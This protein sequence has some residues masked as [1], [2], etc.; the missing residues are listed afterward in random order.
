MSEPLRTWAERRPR[1]A[2]LLAFLLYLP[3]L[4]SPFLYDDLVVIVDNLSIRDLGAPMSVLLYDRAR[5]LLNLSWAINYSMSGLEPWSYHLVNALIH[6]G[7]SALLA[8]LFEWMAAR[9]GAA[10]PRRVA[11]AGACFFAV[12]PMAVETVAYVASRSTALSALFAIAS[13]RLASSVLVGGP[14]WRLAAA[15]ALFVLALATKEEAAAVPL[16]LLLLDAFFV[17]RPTAR[18]MARR[19]S[20]HAPFIGLVLL[21]LVLRRASTG[22]WLPPPESDRLQYA[23]TQLAAFPVYLF[24]QLVPLDPALYRG[25]GP[26][27]SAEARL[28]LLIAC[29]AVVA[30][31]FAMRT[32]RPQ[33]S[34]AVAWLAA[35][36]SPS[37][38]IVPLGETMADHRAYVGGAGVAYCVGGLLARPG[39]ALPAV[40]L[41]AL[42]AARN[43][44]YQRV[45]ADPVSAWEDAVRRAPRPVAGLRLLA[46]AY[47]SRNDAGAAEAALL[48][49]VAIDATDYKSWTNLGVLY[50]RMGRPDDAEQALRRA[51]AAAPAGHDRAFIHDNLAQLLEG[52]GRTEEAIAEFLAAIADHPRFAQP[53][54]LLAQIL[55]E[56]GD[57]AR[58]MALLDEASKCPLK[59]E[60]AEGIARLRAARRQ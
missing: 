29:A 20:I 56:R 18:D 16:L 37:S 4:G 9:A 28:V 43:V 53:R 5:P 50:G 60:E 21:G 32:S 59:P 41:L 12:S 14:R 51:L 6:A 54:I 2:A 34:F 55:L 10:Q 47:A 25:H 27:W 13:L 3:S 30:V 46:D 11:L 40:G 31:A 17:A 49:A 44:Q 7:N 19:L 52:L 58:A 23:L 8:S 36:L 57:A 39:A 38:S 45:L 22:S 33:V 26:P 48:R 35:A 24:R 15:L 1:V 42:L